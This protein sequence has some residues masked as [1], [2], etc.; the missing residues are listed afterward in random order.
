MS[1]I[2]PMIPKH[3]HEIVGSPFGTLIGIS[4]EIWREYCENI[5]DTISDDAFILLNCNGVI[6]ENELVAIP[7]S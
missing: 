2:V 5:Q 7:F 3:L 6:C 1:P 4:T